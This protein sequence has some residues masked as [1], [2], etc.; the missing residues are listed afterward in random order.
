MVGIVL[1]FHMKESSAICQLPLSKEVPFLVFSQKCSKQE[2]RDV[3]GE[4]EAPLGC[5]VGRADLS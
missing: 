4:G 5:W 3:C 1:L 2:V